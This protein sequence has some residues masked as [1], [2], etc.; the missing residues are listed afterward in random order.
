MSSTPMN[1]TFFIVG[2]LARRN[3][4]KRKLNE[5]RKDL[6]ESTVTHV[7][8][9]TEETAVDVLDDGAGGDCARVLVLGLVHPLRPNL[10][11]DSFQ[12]SIFYSDKAEQDWTRSSTAFRESSPK[13]IHT[14]CQ[15]YQEWGRTCQSHICV[16]T[17]WAEFS[18]RKKC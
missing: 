11:A 13:N 14:I 6:H 1:V 12:F 18:F 15:Y 2:S 5:G 7:D 4:K 9:V 16:P 3:G 8:D 10:E 17:S